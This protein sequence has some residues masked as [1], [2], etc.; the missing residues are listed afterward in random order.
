MILLSI[1]LSWFAPP[2]CERPTMAVAT[3]YDSPE[4]DRF[5]SGTDACTHKPLDEEQLGIA[6]RTLP[7][8]AHV[9]V[10][11]PRTGR[12]TIATVTDRGPFGINARGVD[13]APAT[14]KAL[15]ANG[16]EPVLIVRVP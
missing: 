14:A 7:C 9:L 11:A 10:Y 8:G 6:H 16:M 3:S 2:V 12:A 4:R 1:I 5:N 13:L 15:R